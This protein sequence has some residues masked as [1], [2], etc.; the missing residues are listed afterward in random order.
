MRGWKIG[1]RRPRDPKSLEQLWAPKPPLRTANFDGGVREPVLTA[2]PRAPAR[3]RETRRIR[4]STVSTGRRHS[5]PARGGTASMM[6]ATPRPKSWS[7]MTRTT[8]TRATGGP[9]AR[10]GPPKGAAAPTTRP[11]GPM[12]DADQPRRPPRA[13]AASQCTPP[14]AGTASP[15]TPSAGAASLRGP[16]ARTCEVASRPSSF[17]STARGLT[18]PPIGRTA[19]GQRPLTTTTLQRRRWQRRQRRRRG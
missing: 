6:L 2:G 8:T 11:T 14:L 7:R 17:P 16:P 15:C 12:M 4:L 3:R 13:G 5:P 1:P 19:P 9:A 18:Q 10:Q